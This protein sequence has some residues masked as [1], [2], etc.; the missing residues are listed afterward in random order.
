ML[1]KEQQSVVDEV[2]G[3][4]NRIVAVNSIAGSGKTATAEAVIRTVNP[5]NGFYTAFNKAIVTDANSRFGSLLDCKTIHS[6]AYKYAKPK[7]IEDFNYNSI[8]EDIPYE[9]KA[10][11][12][13][14]LDDF[15]RSDSVDVYQFVSDTSTTDDIRNLVCD[16]AELM[17]ARKIP[18]TFNFLL[19][20]L[21]IM[22]VNGE[23]TIDKDLLIL[24]ECQDTTAVTLQI[25]KN[26][27]C[28][29]KVIFGDRFQ[30]IY[31]FMNT[32]NAFE[33]LDNL[34][35]IRLTKSF[36]CHPT[37]ASQVEL[38]GRQYLE[39]DFKYKGNE[40]IKPKDTPELAY[41]SRNNS[42][43][44]ERMHKLISKGES[45]K[46]IRPAKEIFERTLA[47]ATAAK[48]DKVLSPKYLFL[49]KEYRKFRDSFGYRNFY[50]YLADVVKDDTINSSAKMLESFR[51]RRIN[52]FGLYKT[53][54]T[55]TPDKHTILTTSHAFKGL[56][57][58]KVMLEDDLNRVVNDI[59]INVLCSNHSNNSTPEHFRSSLT[60]EE[61]ENLNTYYVALSRAKTSLSNVAYAHLRY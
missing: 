12:I 36:R 17:L 2:L 8:T 45:F 4:D 32:V 47:V 5:K 13:Q 44:I 29:K 59:S 55:M 54:Q 27:N 39:E 49:N 34:N 7:Y 3:N 51:D 61:K 42:T 38:F 50:E 18:V 20:Y 57:A 10:E 58:D 40:D 56:E 16:Y 11:V 6:L 35:L 22:L 48:G 24:D 37:I 23:I 21:H 41:I 52:I 14:I 25:F 53:V 9:D 43:L 60:K 26:I 28:D 31:S 15:F 30:N 46:L 33:E 1:T 19:K